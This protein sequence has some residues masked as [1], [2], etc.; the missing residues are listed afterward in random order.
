[1]MIREIFA[2]FQTVKADPHHSVWHPLQLYVQSTLA[3]FLTGVTMVHVELGIR[4]GA[5]VLAMI[6]STMTIYK[7]YLDIR[8]KRKSLL[9]NTNP[10][11]DE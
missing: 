10:K 5:G 7:I 6:L 8:I 4:I 11:I 3:F 1:M 2:Q 9:E